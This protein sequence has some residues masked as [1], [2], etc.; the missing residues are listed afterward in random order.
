MTRKPQLLLLAGLLVAALAVVAAVGLQNP[1]GPTQVS[2]AESVPM[3]A[4]AKTSF[5]GLAA[6]T[7]DEP[8]LTGLHTTA[9]I[10]GQIVQVAGPFDD[11]FVLKDLAFDGSA[12]MGTV[13]VTNDVSDLLELQVLAGFYD[14][15]GALLVTDR[16]I[17]DMRSEGQNHPRS[18]EE[19]EEFIIR[20]PP[21]FQGKAVSAAVGV[22]VLVNE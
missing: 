14:E 22:P 20:V 21:E 10:K 2:A 16:I 7:E 15:K 19:R 1:A 9:P 11:R 13:T 12:A 5:P 17:R 8:D 18:A 6:A 4:A 3:A